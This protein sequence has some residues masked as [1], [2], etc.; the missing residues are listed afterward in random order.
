MEKKQAA[1]GGQENV[2]TTVVPSAGD[3]SPT[4][5]KR[6]SSD[7]FSENANTAKRTK[8]GAQSRPSASAEESEAES[9]EGSDEEG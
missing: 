6:K 2:P 4:A 1:T 7:A 8:L 9:A 5:Q 3:S